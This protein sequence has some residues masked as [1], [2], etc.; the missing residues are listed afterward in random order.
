MFGFPGGGKTHQQLTD[1]GLQGV[2]YVAPSY[3][4]LTEKTDRYG[5]EAM[6]KAVC[7]GDNEQSWRRAVRYSSTFVYDEVSEWTTGYL[8]KA[9]ERFPYHQ[10]ILCG[11]PGYQ[12]GPVSEAAPLTVA[13]FAHPITRYDWSFRCKCESLRSL[14]NKLR[15][16]IDDNLSSDEMCDLVRR[17]LPASQVVTFEEC[18]SH[19]R[20]VDTVLVS[21]HAAGQEYTEKLTPADGDRKYRIGKHAPLPNGRIV[22]AAS[23]P[24]PQAVEAYASTIHG[25]QGRDVLSPDRLFID[26]RRMFCREHWYVAVSRPE[27]LSQLFLVQPRAAEE[28]ASMHLRT[29]RYT[30]CA[31]FTRHWCTSDSR[32][33]R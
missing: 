3:E 32:Q 11:D 1:A 16:A 28:V 12:L 26:S 20:L 2:L 4:L 17:A 6:V 33:V 30:S 10:H 18:V 14:Q 5:V 9:I 24:C 7:L 25:F 19:Y 13:S 29:Q 8:Q 31:R 27:Y 23:P 21:T 22:I 15:H